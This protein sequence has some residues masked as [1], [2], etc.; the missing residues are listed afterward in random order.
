MNSSTDSPN[1]ATTPPLLLGEKA[2]DFPLGDQLPA[3]GEAISVAPGVLW[4]RMSLPFALDHINLWLLED[5]ES[6]SEGTRHGWTAVD[7]GVTNDGTQAAWEQLF[8]DVLKNLPILRV[9]V[10]HMHPDHM[11][12]AHWLC[13]K[14]KA[15]LWMSA[16]EYQSALLGS[17]GTS[18]FG[19]PSTQ[20][21]FADHGWRDPAD[22]AQVNERIAYYGDMVPSVPRSYHRLFEGTTLT[23]GGQSWRCISG[24]GH[25]PEHMALFCDAT[26]TLISGDMVLPKIS[27]NVSVSAQEPESNSLALFLASLKKFDSL[28]EDTLVLPSHGRPFRGLHKRTAQLHEHHADRLQEVLAACS[29]KPGSAFDM[30]PVLFK[31]PLNFHQT[32]FA[33]GESVAHLHTLWYEGKVDRIKDAQGVW[34]FCAIA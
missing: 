8:I 23:I 26:H 5:S 27:T 33:M 16:T 20:R 21:F 22:Q 18:D 30:L 11:G 1:K 34:R 17:T 31:R 9:V 3:L 19:G 12:L 24:W 13:A 15:P 29:Q 10:T 32:T 28:P 6:T 14:F 7:C 2:L 25:S 4:I